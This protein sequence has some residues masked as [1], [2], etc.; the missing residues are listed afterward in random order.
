MYSYNN[1]KDVKCLKCKESPKMGIS[2][3]LEV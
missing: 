2:T 3:L 1:I